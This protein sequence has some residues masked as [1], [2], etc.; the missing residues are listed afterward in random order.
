MIFHDAVLHIFSENWEKKI[1][2]IIR[3]VWEIKV[4][5]VVYIQK[6]VEIEAEIV[7]VI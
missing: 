5:V 3:E 6:V 2:A 7:L 1:I 4:E